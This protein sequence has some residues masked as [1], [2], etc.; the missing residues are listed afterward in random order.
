MVDDRNYMEKA[1]AP[2]E[3]RYKSQC[4]AAT[5]GHLAAKKNIKYKGEIIFGLS[6]YGDMGV[7]KA[8]LKGKTEE[9]DGGPW[10][11]EALFDFL[12]TLNAEEGV[13][14]SWT[15]YF[16]NYEFVGRLEPL[17]DFRSK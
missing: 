10:F 7:Y 4:L 9:L 8:D 13:I 5:W 12:F 6:L 15:G 3:A 2:A 1:F 17:F 11:Y 14:Y 16:K